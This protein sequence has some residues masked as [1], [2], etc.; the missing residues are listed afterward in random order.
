MS[1]SAVASRPSLVLL[2]LLAHAAALFGQESR[3]ASRP[4]R[5]L[6][7]TGSAGLLRDLDDDGRPDA[8]R[9]LRLVVEGF[10][11]GDDPAAAAAA[12]AEVFARLG[13][14][15][16]AAADPLAAG[17]AAAGDVA[18]LTFRR[19]AGAATTFEVD[20]SGALAAAGERAVDV[21]AAARRA[22]A[23]WPDDFDVAAAETRPAAPRSGKERR[24]GLEKLFDVGGLLVDQDGDLVPDGADCTVLPSGE[25]GSVEATA[26]VAFRMGLESAGLRFP[27]A[28]T[29]AEW[30]KEK[31]AGPVV[32]IGSRQP[33]AD[34]LRRRG[35]LDEDPPAGV[36]EVR[37][38]DGAFGKHAAVVVRGGDAE[39]LVRAGRLA[40]EKIPYFV[41]ERLGGPTL[42]DLATEA[43]RLVAG[44]SE[45]GKRARVARELKILA[46]QVDGPCD[47]VHVYTDAAPSGRARAAAA[48]RWI[49]AIGGTPMRPQGAAFE[50]DHRVGRFD[51]ATVSEIVELSPRWEVDRALEVAA[52]ALR[53]AGDGAAVVVEVDVSEPPGERATLAA[54]LR[55]LVPEAARTRAEIVVR[56]AWKPAYFR[57]VE[58]LLPLW[59]GAPPRRIELGAR[60]RR[61]DGPAGVPSTLE[62]PSRAALELYPLDDVLARELGLE[63]GRDVVVALL[64]ETT[65]TEYVVRWT[66]ADGAERV[67]AF[68]VRRRE[69][70]FNDLRPDL[71]RV[72]VWTGGVRVTID[73]R[74]VAD[75]DVTTDLEELWNGYQTQ[76][77]PT[78]R[79]VLLRGARGRPEP[80]H[81]PWFRHVL[82]DAVLSEPD[83]AL[84]DGLGRT[85]AIDMLH[86]ELYFHT[87]GFV[88]TTGAL[89]TDKP[90]EFTGRVIPT[91]DGGPGW[92]PRMTVDVGPRVAQ[93]PRIDAWRRDADGVERVVATRE[94]RPIDVREP[95]VS[96][97]RVDPDGGL[98]ATVAFRCDVVADDRAAWLVRM[99]P[100]DADVKT[101]AVEQGA[102]TVA[103]AAAHRAVGARRTEWFGYP[104]LRRV[105]FAFSAE[106]TTRVAT[107]DVDGVWDAPEPNPSNA[108]LAFLPDDRA[109]DSLEAGGVLAALAEKHAGVG[110]RMYHAGAST[111]GRDLW[112]AET[113]PFDPPTDDA[114]SRPRHFSRRKLSAWKPT[115]AISAREH[116]NEVSSTTHVLQWFRDVLETDPGLLRRVRVVVNPVWNADGADLAVELAG[117][118]PDD[119]LHAGYLG[120]FGENLT[121][122]QDER[123]PVHR[124]ARLRLDLFAAHLPDVFF[125]PHGYPMHEWVQPFSGYAAWVKKRDPKT[126]D[127]WIPRGAFIQ[128]FTFADDEAEPGCRR[129]ADD[130]KRRL[131]AALRASPAVRALSDDQYARYARWSAFLPD[132][133]R[134][135][136]VDGAAVYGPIRGVDEKKDGVQFVQR[137]PKTCVA[138]VI[139]EVPDETARGEHLRTV[140]AAG[141]SVSAALA[142]FLSE[143]SKFPDVKVTPHRDGATRVR[144]RRRVE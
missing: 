10:D 135:P 142:A 79:D 26:Y 74:V 25:A 1:K 119:L 85:S 78:L 73:G 128:S 43:R 7:G 75:V 64:P 8:V 17:D 144:A 111:Y 98:E 88:Q 84:P 32:L 143:R 13:L 99:R 19:A 141:R 103:E 11:V 2:L 18:T 46:A 23:A 28:Q 38:I 91:I 68:D 125:N 50:I 5:S 96:A 63:V 131:A 89:W 69:R 82:F 48:G 83:E 44:V 109:L 87:L 57:I 51:V 3:P 138:N 108:P 86:E 136:L 47:G 100:E 54:R 9:P 52:E 81:A 41:V 124:E 139:L 97:L 56:S 20:A 112:I 76:V 130:L 118:R 134:L 31:V 62:P 92:A 22:A 59:R 36:G 114:P 14:E 116:A 105:R 55:D 94:M 120:P 27:V 117:R 106:G 70:A 115:L 35:L 42:A 40:F 110:L 127:W 58:E 66:E 21:L 77:L 123:D 39:G 65:A 133:L 37:V 12:V 24:F 67:E 33:L 137:A 34:D 60:R 16:C 101:F 6:F 104:D 121:V 45:E 29:P 4:S 30:P 126:R 122:G 93:G 80:R 129:I 72:S 95:R 71:E 49:A 61:V 113:G 53:G 132:D 102:A 107:L 140:C 15:T 90:F